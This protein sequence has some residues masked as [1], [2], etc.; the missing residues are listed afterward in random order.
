[1]AASTGNNVAIFQRS[2]AGLAPLALRANRGKRFEKRA[3]IGNFFSPA[4]NPF[5]LSL[6]SLFLRCQDSVQIYNFRWFNFLKARRKFE[7]DS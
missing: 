2:S 6:L 1:M 7:I 3:K 4:A 5:L